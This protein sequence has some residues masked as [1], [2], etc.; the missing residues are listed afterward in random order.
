M[1]ASR[2]AGTPSAKARRGEACA[3]RPR[4]ELHE[5][6]AGMFFVVFQQEADDLVLALGGGLGHQARAQGLGVGPDAEH[7][8]SAV[9]RQ[10]A[11][12]GRRHRHVGE[13]DG[14]DGRQAQGQ[15]IGGSR[16]GHAGQ[17]KAA[18]A[19]HAGD[20]HT[21]QGAPARAQQRHRDDRQEAPGEAQ[22][23]GLQDGAPHG[24]RGGRRSLGTPA[25]AHPAP[26]AQPGHA[27]HHARPDEK[28]TAMHL[29]PDR[30]V[31]DA[32]VEHVCEHGGGREAQ[33]GLQLP[34][35]EA[36][37]LG[38]F[39]LVGLELGP[40]AASAPHGVGADQG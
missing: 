24:T 1:L 17:G 6:V 13:G 10:E 37:G 9:E 29:G 19:D 28:R 39:G 8:Q 4:I 23:G 35:T 31:D 38:F 7:H 21:H 40:N 27:Q 20:H 34:G 30:P 12:Q 2:E 15:D 14:K 3:K 16:P 32:D 33:H 5:Q 18:G 22:R 26:E 25:G 11:A 36:R